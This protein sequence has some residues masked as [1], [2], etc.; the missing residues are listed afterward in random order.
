M[1]MTPVSRSYAIGGHLF[2]V[3]PLPSALYVVATPIGNLED[4]S[5][6]ALAT[7][8]ACDAVLAEDTRVSRKLLQRYAISTRLIAYHEHNAEE[9]RPKILAKLEKGSSIA[10]ISDAGTP[11]VSDPGFKLVRELAE[12]GH[13]VVPLP[14]AS[15]VLAGLVVSGLPS[16]RFFFEGFLPP[17][18]IARQN[19]LQ[20]LKDIPSTLI[21]FESGPRLAESLKDMAQVLGMRQAVMAREL[22]K[23]FE[24]VHRGMLDALS[25]HYAQNLP[26]KG[27]IVV[28]VGP[29]GPISA[30]SEA[31]IDRDLTQLLQRAS[32]KDAVGEVAR[33]N[34][35]PRKAVYARALALVAGDHGEST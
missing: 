13:K 18:T 17:K 30:V 22:T 4:I 8:A 14:G 1:F 23:S 16:D 6:R 3:P 33:V 2:V 29:P 5:L 9:M 12:Q 24:T 20:G 26:P 10:L 34:R 19:R 25:D 28:M 31:D 32:L 11:L 7:L 15:A 27:E 21:F 35:W